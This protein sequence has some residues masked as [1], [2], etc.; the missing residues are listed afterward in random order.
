MGKIIRA[1]RIGKGGPVYKSHGHFKLGD[2]T[3]SS[4][5]TILR[6]KETVRG[7]IINFIHERG[8]TAPLALVKLETGEKILYLPPEGAHLGQKIE[9]GSRAK[10]ERGN[11]LPLNLIPE[12]TKIYNV[13]HQPFDGGKFIKAAGTYGLVVGREDG[14][15][16]V[17]LSSGKGK[18][19]HKNC[20]ATIGIVAGGGVKE[21]PFLKAGTKYYYARSRRKKWPIVRGVAMNPV[22]HPHGGGSHQHPGGSTTVSRHAPPGAKVGHIAASQT[23]RGKKRRKR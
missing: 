14:K 2:I 7:E 5:H 15:V 21:K 1:Q 6:E 13:E 19:L 20:F 22:D 17:K 12:G 3:Y 9:I 8:R 10:P 23:G 4:L 18:L 16:K 11:I